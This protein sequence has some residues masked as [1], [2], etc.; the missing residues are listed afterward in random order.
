MI[1][2]E[3]A[4]PADARDERLEAEINAAFRRMEGASERDAS[5]T[6]TEIAVLLRRRSHAMVLLAELRWRARARERGQT[7]DRKTP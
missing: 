7:I 1:T 6:L 3:I 5:A 4:R 2:N